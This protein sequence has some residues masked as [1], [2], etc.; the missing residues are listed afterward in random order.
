MNVRVGKSHW[1]KWNWVLHF[2]P[3]LNFGCEHLRY[4]SEQYHLTLGW[5]FW[6]IEFEWYKS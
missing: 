1:G 3:Y 6:W 2:L 4:F 5:L